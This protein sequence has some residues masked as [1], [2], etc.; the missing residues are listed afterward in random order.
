MTARVSWSWA[1]FAIAALQAGFCLLLGLFAILAIREGSGT[2]L[3]FQMGRTTYWVAGVVQCSLLGMAVIGLSRWIANRT[4]RPVRMFVVLTVALPVCLL[5]ALAVLA[6][7]TT[8]ARG[9]PLLAPMRWL[10]VPLF[11][12]TF[13]AAAL[14]YLAVAKA[15]SSRTNS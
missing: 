13:Y 1:A 14:T 6:L 2:D 5:L 7:S 8:G 9:L 4:R 10:E 15:G 3:R 11:A 12:L